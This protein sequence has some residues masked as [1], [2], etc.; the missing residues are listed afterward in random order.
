MVW[1]RKANNL[2]LKTDLC[3]HII[4]DPILLILAVEYA[5]M[6][7]TDLNSI[8]NRLIEVIIISLKKATCTYYVT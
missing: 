7:T 6:L 2:G 8:Y 5:L 3:R 4:K 1:I